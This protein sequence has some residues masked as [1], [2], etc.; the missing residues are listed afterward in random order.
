MTTIIIESIPLLQQAILQQLESNGYKSIVPSPQA[1]KN[2][3]EFVQSQD[4][5]L[6]WLDGQLPDLREGELIKQLRLAA[7]HAKILLYSSGDRIPEIKNFFKKGIHAYLMKTAEAME[8]SAA[9]DALRQDELYVPPAL[10]KLFASWMTDPVRKKKPGHELT[11]REKEVLQL[12]VDEYT[13]NEIAK[14]LYIS[15]CTVE[16]HRINL[17]QKLGV[18]N[19]AGLVRV[20]FEAGLYSCS[21][22]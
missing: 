15:H 12:I 19:T 18:K 1:I 17:I 14:K 22:V 10:N 7:P 4:A 8:I 6:I 3:P 9:L 2:L 11:C 16:T 5:A 20:A 13:T 21:I